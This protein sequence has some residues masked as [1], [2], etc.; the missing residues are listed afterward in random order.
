MRDLYRDRPYAAGYPDLEARGVE[1]YAKHQDMGVDDGT[2]RGMTI[3]DLVARLIDLSGAGR[4]V[5]V[6]GCGPQPLA[7]RNLI[8]QGYDAVGIEPVE[9]S[10][11][12]AREFLGDPSQALRGAAESLPLPDASQRVVLLEAVL[13]HVDA[14]H[15]S[16]EECH[17]VLEPGGVLYVYTTNRFRFSLRGRN[18]EYEVP[19]YN[20]F[21]RIVK[22]SYVFHHLH[23]DPRLANYTPR[24][25]VHWFSYSDLCALG[26]D[27]GFGQFYSKLDLADANS[28]QIRRRAVTRFLYRYAKFHPWLRALALLH[29]GNSIFMLKRPSS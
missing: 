1:W 23:Y 21:P 13:E 20:W 17:R 25:A 15:L 14:P 28:P 8:E 3:M 22:E 7:V 12:A 9:G 16:L 29:Y 19:F 11:K 10:V 5:A 18:G 6:V 27:A 2:V 26:R 24:P 4:K